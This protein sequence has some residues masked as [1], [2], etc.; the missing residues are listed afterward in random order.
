MNNSTKENSKESVLITIV[1]GKGGTGKDL[2]SVNLGEILAQRGFKILTVD[3][4]PLA[5]L[6]AN[7]RNYLN[8]EDLQKKMNI[9]TLVNLLKEGKEVDFDNAVLRTLNQ[10]HY[11]MRGKGTNLMNYDLLP[12]EIRERLLDGIGYLGEKNGYDFVLLNSGAGAGPA[13]IS[14]TVRSNE[15]LL[16]TESDPGAMEDAENLARECFKA[17]AFE[18]ITNLE[19]LEEA[20][21]SRLAKQR[22]DVLNAYE[23]FKSGD[24]SARGEVFD[25]IK[26]GWLRY[27]QKEGCGIN[28]G[29]VMNKV[30]PKAK[31][32]D[33]ANDLYD[34]LENRLTKAGVTIKPI[35]DRYNCLIFN[36]ES[37]EFDNSKWEKVPYMFKSEKGKSRSWLPFGRKLKGNRLETVLE[38]IADH[39]G[40]YG[41]LGLY[42]NGG[43]GKK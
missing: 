27:L 14:T 8:Q 4:D 6:H 43:N 32:T 19:C 2:I 3:L 28:F 20:M 18:Y 25:W 11:V 16:I 29:V 30:N 12:A 35:P 10:N 26:N 24:I 1:S 36:E 39:I 31:G 34:H 23:K 42:R 40:N 41:G 17:A 22:K 37:K 21:T 5:K 38:K 15:R 7:N 9:A 13:V 33:I